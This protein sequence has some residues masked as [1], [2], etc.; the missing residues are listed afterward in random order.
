MIIGNVIG[1]VV[2]TMKL[3]ILEGYKLLIVEPVTP[4]GKPNGTT[5]VAL[6]TV[7]AGIGD[8]VLLLEEGNSARMI[9]GDPMGAV[10]SVIVG[11]IDRIEVYKE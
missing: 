11:I 9:V 2:S 1:N 7:Q 6:D 5:A 8:T 10:R 4:E 3:P